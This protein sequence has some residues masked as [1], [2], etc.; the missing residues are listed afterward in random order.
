MRRANGQKS[1][2]ELVTAAEIAISKKTIFR[3]Q[4]LQLAQTHPPSGKL[5]GIYATGTGVSQII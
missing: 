5:L 2:P 4:P 1:S 3:A